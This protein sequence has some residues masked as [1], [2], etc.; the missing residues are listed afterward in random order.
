MGPTFDVPESLVE[1]F[2]HFWPEEFLQQICVQTNV[3]DRE[4]MGPDKYE[5]WVDVT[6][7]EFKA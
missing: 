4:V 1:V 6:V 3:Y 5:E 7:E 2:L